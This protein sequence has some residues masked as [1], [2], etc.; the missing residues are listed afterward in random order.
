MTFRAVAFTKTSEIGPS[1]RYR[2]LQM[3]PHLA[4]HGVSLTCRPLFGATWFAIL[5]QPAP[6][7]LAAK[8]AYTLGR[9]A[10]R[11]AQLL[12]LVLRR[13]RPDLVVIEHQLFP[14]L[15]PWFERWLRRR[16][17]RFTVEFDD[18]IHLT[19]FH[20]RKMETL[21][22]LADAVI[23]GN[24]EL[25]AFA[26]RHTDKVGVV[27]TT[28]EME[29]YPTPTLGER[30]AALDPERPLV[31][32]WIGLPYNFHALDIVTE[33]LR[34]LAAQRPIRLR[35]VSDGAPRLP[36][37]PTEVVPWSAAREV[38]EIRGFDVGIMPLPDDAWSRGKCALKILQYFAA[39]RP[40]VASPVGANAQVVHHGRDG[41][42]ARGPDEWYEA[43]R[44][45]ADDPARRREM[46][47]EGRR[48]VEREYAT[49]SW[50]PRL[51]AAWRAAAAGRTPETEAERE[52]KT[53][54][55]DERENSSMTDA[56]SGAAP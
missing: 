52:P 12:I 6:L 23:V 36:G 16:G 3:V 10:V 54:N 42:L 55:E 38:D 26:R 46:G 37:V 1:S 17:V 51:A 53:E 28:I 45:L 30:D 47:L 7:R 22:A 40:A 21:C 31:V 49:A 8:L 18:A 4:R 48:A 29:R 14:Y 11:A 9:F 39:G 19:R 25:R 20:L 34:R 56:G 41:F 50:A 32:G 24:P 44:A 13:R 15:P 2:Y 33:P 5:R 27:P 35:V 43:L